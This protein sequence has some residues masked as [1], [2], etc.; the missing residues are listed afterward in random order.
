MNDIVFMI[1]QVVVA[2]SMVLLMR[3]ILPYLKYKVVGIIDEKVWDIV[4]KE[5]KSVE[6]S[7]AGSGMGKV[8]KEQVILRV[9]SWANQHGITITQDQISQL[10]ETAVWI[11][12]NEDK[13]N[14]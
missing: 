10:I 11:M 9:T 3:Y 13:I 1:L 14:G 5:V 8:K 4:I 6:Q 12:N 2:I 7:I